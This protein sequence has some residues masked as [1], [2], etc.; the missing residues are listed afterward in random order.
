MIA[1]IIYQHVIAG[2]HVALDTLRPGGPG[3]MEMMF[4]G[5]YNDKNTWLM[6]R[7]Q[8]FKGRT[9]CT[10]RILAT[11]AARGKLTEFTQ[12]IVDQSCRRDAAGL[13]QFMGIVKALQPVLMRVTKTGRTYTVSARFEGAKKP[14]WIAMRK[15]T[16]LR[17]KGGLAFGMSMWGK[18]GG[19]GVLNVDWVK[20]E[21]L[22]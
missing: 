15:L 1:P 7:L 6:A 3:R 2:R 16:L 21:T 14:K 12:N 22:E 4:F 19:E 18:S 20:I 10:V 17:A 8:A 11:K 5:I 9:W 13:K